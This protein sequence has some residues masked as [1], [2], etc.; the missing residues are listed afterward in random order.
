[1][2]C[3]QLM[4]NDSRPTREESPRFNPPTSAPPPFGNNKGNPSVG[5]QTQES[6][7]PGE[8]PIKANQR[9]A[10]HSIA[11]QPVEKYQLT[12]VAYYS[13]SFTPMFIFVHTRKYYRIRIRMGIWEGLRPHYYYGCA[14]GD[15]GLLIIL[16]F[17]PRR[18]RP[19]SQLSA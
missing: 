19:H 10:S 18:P 4:K 15:F 9:G 16:L 13:H 11:A 12:A 1:V 5:K 7:G 8:D 14:Q 17:L 6:C 2:C 3:P